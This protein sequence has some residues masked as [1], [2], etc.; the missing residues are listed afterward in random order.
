MT[1]VLTQVTIPML[2]QPTS[3]PPTTINVYAFQD[4]TGNYYLGSQPATDGI[5]V[6]VAHPMQVTD[7]AAETSLASVVTN[8]GATTTV[9]GTIATNTTGLATAANQTTGNTS[10]DA[11][12]T[13][14]G[15][16]SD[17]A[18]SGSGSGSLVA[19][20]KAVF[21]SLASLITNTTGLATAATQTA[22]A[23]SL[24][25]IATN[26]P[27]KV[28]AGT[29]IPSATT[30]LT[31]Q[32]AATSQV[33]VAASVIPNNLIIRN[34]ATAVGQGFAS[35]ATAE[36]MFIDVTNHNAVGTAGSSSLELLPGDSWESNGSYSTPVNWY[37]ATVGH[38]ITAWME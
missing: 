10:A 6:G 30:A 23:T 28:R 29:Q 4:P 11:T 1:E 35:T 16:P 3:G 38:K 31:L 14:V 18:W 20:L 17:T 26:T 21:G 36:S 9:L 12:A 19:L 27:A 25:T 5:N 24:S 37:A 7:A 8:T 22:S 13:G 33:L 15:T 2:I 34:P 32:V